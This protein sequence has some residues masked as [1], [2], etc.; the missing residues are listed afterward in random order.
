MLLVLTVLLKHIRKAG[1]WSAA[2]HSPAGSVGKN[3]EERTQKQLVT[4]IWKAS[5]PCCRLAAQPVLRHFRGKSGKRWDETRSDT[6]GGTVEKWQDRT[7][8][9][10]LEGRLLQ[11]DTRRLRSTDV[12]GF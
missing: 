12:D 6:A 5:H 8:R 2:C 7:C 3:P 10:G 11:D 9:Q 4:V 1:Y